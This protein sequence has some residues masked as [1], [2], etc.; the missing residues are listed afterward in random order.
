MWKHFGADKRNR[1]YRYTGSVMAGKLNVPMSAYQFFQERCDRQRQICPEKGCN[2][3][4]CFPPTPNLRIQTE[5][6]CS[7]SGLRPQAPGLISSSENRLISS[8]LAKFVR[9]CTEGLT[10]LTATGQIFGLGQLADCLSKFSMFLSRRLTLSLPVSS[11][12]TVE[13]I[14]CIF[15]SYTSIIQEFLLPRLATNGIY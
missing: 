1:R 3:K 8:L 2:P 4:L 9:T 13:S 7:C 11:L 14:I 12:L 10:T 6:V 5:E 15:S